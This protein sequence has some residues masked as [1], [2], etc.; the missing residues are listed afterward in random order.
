MGSIIVAM[1]RSEDAKKISEMLKAR[2]IHEI[3]ICTTGSS[4]LSKVHQ[5]DS[6]IVVC[7]RKFKD[8]Y[9]NEIAESLP[10]YFR[11]LLLV[12]G[13]NLE[14]CPTGIKAMTM[15]FMASEL[16]AQVNSMMDEIDYIIR[17]ERS[18]PRK[19]SKEEQE[20]IDRAKRLLMEKNSMTEQE[21]FRYIQ[22]S[23]M[24]S[25]TNMIETAQMILM[26]YETV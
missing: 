5:L 4:I 23:S 10:E 9:C 22:K 13:E 8:M 16:V 12:S 15:P 2:G 14:Y 25:C 17:R 18:K 20:C 21:A 11:M 7:T 1:P 19:R 24:D 6:G 26:L 3:D